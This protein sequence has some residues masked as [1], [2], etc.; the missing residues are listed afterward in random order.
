VMVASGWYNGWQKRT[1][2]GY[3]KRQGIRTELIVVLQANLTSNYPAI[4]NRGFKVMR[5][6]LWQAKCSD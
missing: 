5:Q 1:L 3:Q 6:K 4:D 2:H